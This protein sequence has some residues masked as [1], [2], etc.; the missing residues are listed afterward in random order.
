MPIKKK[1]P[2][3]KNKWDMQRYTD[4]H[5]IIWMSHTMKVYKKVIEQR[6]ESTISENQPRRSTIEVTSRHR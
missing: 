5:G 6:Q 4:Y 1:A 3:Y 2:I